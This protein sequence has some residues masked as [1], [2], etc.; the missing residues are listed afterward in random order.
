MTEL[1][2]KIY[3]GETSDSEWSDF[4]LDI[5]L[6]QHLNARIPRLLPQGTLVAHKT[7][8]IGLVRN[9]AG[10][11]Y[12]SDD[13][14]VVLSVFVLWDLPQD[15]P[16]ATLKRTFEVETAMGEISLLAYDAFR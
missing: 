16:V 2:R 10:I 12:V 9:D 13:S 4:A 15:D 3:A 1:L 6:H 11:I 5:L 14:H 7:G 8:T